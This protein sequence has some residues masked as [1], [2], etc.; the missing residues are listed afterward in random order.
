MSFIKPVLF[1]VFLACLTPGWAQNKP[2]VTI[3][4]MHQVWHA[5]IINRNVFLGLISGYISIGFIGSFLFT[6]IELYSPGSF[7]GLSQVVTGLHSAEELLYL[8]FI[9]LLTIGYGDLLPVTS[10]AHKATILIGLVG[11]FYLVLVTAVV[12]SKYIHSEITKK[13]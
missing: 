10:V 11:Q 5:E 13:S 1:T 9:S 3:E 12:V 8:S 2:E 6:W 7:S 4:I